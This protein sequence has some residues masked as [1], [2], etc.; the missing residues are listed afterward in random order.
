MR[1]IVYIDGFNLYNRR[2]KNRPQWKWLNPKALADNILS[3]PMVVTRVNYYT[4][5]V[6]AKIDPGAPQRQGAYLKALVSVPEMKI[7]YGKFLYTEHWAAP[8]EPPDTRPKD[9]QWPQPLLC[10]S[11]LLWSAAH[12]VPP[13]GSSQAMNVP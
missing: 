11:S 3:A 9:Y 2:L 4:A 13:L 12:T 8:A 6:S 5:R 7:H 10:P 1:T